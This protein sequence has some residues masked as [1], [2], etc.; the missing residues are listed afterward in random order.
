MNYCG[1]RPTG[2]TASHEGEGLNSVVILCNWAEGGAP[3][4]VQAVDQ[5]KRAGQV[6]PAFGDGILYLV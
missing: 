4:C 1:E 5:D 2:F 6:L 3:Q